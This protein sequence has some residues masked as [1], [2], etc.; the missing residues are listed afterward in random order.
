[1]ANYRHLSFEILFFLTELREDI[2]ALLNDSLKNV[3][4]K[5]RV[6]VAHSIGHS[7]V[8]HLSSIAYMRRY[9][10]LLHSLGY[11]RLLNECLPIDA[12][13]DDFIITL[14]V[15]AFNNFVY[16][17]QKVFLLSLLCFKITA[18]PMNN[19]DKIDLFFSVA[20]DDFKAKVLKRSK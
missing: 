7:D 4:S 20:F 17:C 10:D 11:I 18:D 2:V 12:M 5:S 19:Q 8:K 14:E 16:P 9:L 3:G 15:A 13:S 1:M 6:Q